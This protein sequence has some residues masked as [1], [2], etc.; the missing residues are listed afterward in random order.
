[1]DHNKHTPDDILRIWK[2]LGEGNLEFMSSTKKTTKNF[3][4]KRFN[5]DQIKSLETTFETEARPELRLKQHLANK[6][7]LQPRQIAIWFQNKRAR[8]KSKQIELEYSMLKSNYDKLASQFAVLREE[9]QTLL[10]QLQRLKKMADKGDGEENEYK[11]DMMTLATSENQ[12]F[13]IDISSHDTSLPSCSDVKRKVDYLEEETDTFDIAQIAEG[14]LASP[15]TG[16]SFQSRTF[17]DNTGSSS[18]WWDF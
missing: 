8:S 17:L 10:I 14:M 12:R 16:C 9:N 1:M 4:R 13:V 6:L 15:E 2:R 5:D 3:N 11:S 18:Q 7:G